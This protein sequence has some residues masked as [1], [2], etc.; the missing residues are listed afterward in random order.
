M[1]APAQSEWAG[2]LAVVLR[3]AERRVSVLL[4]DSRAG[5]PDLSSSTDS[6]L[7]R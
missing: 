6:R 5:S 2:R 4:L 1:A 3:A 7:I